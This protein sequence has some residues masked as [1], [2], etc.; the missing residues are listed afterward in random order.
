MGRRALVLGGGG[1]LGAAWMVGALTAL[2]EHEGIDARHYDLIVGTSAGSVIGSLLACGVSVAELR[3]QQL[4]GQVTTGPLAGYAWDDETATGGDRPPWPK[5]ALG[6]IELLRRG[7]KELGQLPPTAVAAAIIPE[8]RGRLDT[9]GAMVRH[10]APAGWA[11]HPR[12]A[13][14]AFDL[15]AGTRVAFGR[16]GSPTVDLADAVMASCAIPGWYEPVSVGGRRYVDG[17]AWSS[18]NADLLIGELLDDIVVIAPQVSFA[19]DQPSRLVTR[20]ERQWRARVTARV[21][22]ELQDV[23]ADGADVTVLGPGPEDLEAFGP[24]MMDVTRRPRVIETSLRTSLSAL[25]QAGELPR[26]SDFDAVA[27][28]LES[29]A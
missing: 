2:E 19:P 12:L 18:T 1:V 23:H 26:A 3:E 10:V 14:T 29:P 4:D 9:V 25:E 7:R 21:L 16:P 22:R 5:A 28:T 6:S 11:R 17:G 27:A 8:G 20:V 24:N 15:D 13:V